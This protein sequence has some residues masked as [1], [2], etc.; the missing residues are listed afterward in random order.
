MV[1]LGIDGTLVK[2]AGS[3]VTPRPKFYSQ[4][5]RG[6]AYLMYTSGSTGQPKGC[7]GSHRGMLN[8]ID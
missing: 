6:V 3:T 4:V 2:A 1:A 8:R 7:L 5:P